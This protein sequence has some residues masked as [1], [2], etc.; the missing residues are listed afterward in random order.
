GG[1]LSKRLPAWQWGLS[2]DGAWKALDKNS[3]SDADL[4]FAYTLLEAGRLW[5]VAEYTR[6]G[7]AMLAL[8]EVEEMV[9]LPGFGTMMLPGKTGFDKDDK[10]WRL[11][12][13]Y[14]PIPLLRRFELEAPS[15][16]W[17]ALAENTAKML[18]RTALHGLAPDWLAYRTGQ[19]GETDFIDDPDKGPIGSYDAIRNY[20]WAGM[21]PMSDP[22][23]GSL[24][25]S[26][27]GMVALTHDRGA[28]PES[29]DTRTGAAKGEGPFGFSAALLPYF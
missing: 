1:D 2:D 18:A 20:L 6:S 28:P 13:S 10:R 4:W 27:G 14:L 29:V 24:M 3:A 22:L 11:N 5:K 8:V 25:Q 16:P 26:L 21:T 17:T 9:D 7:L 19:E 15:G 12:P 23:F